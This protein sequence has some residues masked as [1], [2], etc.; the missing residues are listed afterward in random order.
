[1]ARNAVGRVAKGIKRE[2]GVSGVV[3][4]FV[5]EE[6]WQQG[7]AFHEFAFVVPVNGE[8][9][10]ANNF[11]WACSIFDVPIYGKKCACFIVFVLNIPKQWR[12]GYMF[13]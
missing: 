4:W 6:N 9:D 2:Q 10:V 7:V 1:M 5:V 12:Y 13:A 3:F 11:A 8:N